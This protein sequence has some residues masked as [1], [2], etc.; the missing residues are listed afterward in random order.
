MTYTCIAYGSLGEMWKL[1]D[2]LGFPAAMPCYDRLC[3]QLLMLSCAE[4]LIIVRQKCFAGRANVEH[5]EL[6]CLAAAD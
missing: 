6:S 5:Y 4:R 3:L 2:S 1:F